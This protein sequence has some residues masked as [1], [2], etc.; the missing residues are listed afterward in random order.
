MVMIHVIFLVLFLV[1]PLIDDR[2]H[3][4]DALGC[5]WGRVSTHPLPADIVVRLLK[6]NGFEKVK[7]FEADP[8][9]LIALGKSGIQVMVGIPNDLLPSLASSVRVAEEWVV[10]NVSVYLSKYGVDIRYIAIGN[11]PFLESN[12]GVFNKV[13][14][15]ALQN[16]QAAIIKAGLSRQVK[17]TVP[18]N[19]NVYQTENGL[20][21]GGNFRSDVLTVVSSIV[22]FLHDNGGFLTINIYP[23]L[24]LHA[25]PNFP[26]TY[27]FF[28]GGTSAPV[29]DGSI[30]YTNVFE[31]NYDTF[32]FALEKNGFPT[33][34]VVVGEIGWPTDGDPNA[35]ANY[36]R[37]F[38]QGLLDRIIRKSGTPKRPNLPPD[39]YIFSLIDENAK[40]IEP[41]NFERHW[42]IFNYDGTIKY[43]L[44]FYN[45]RSLVAAK[46]VKYMEKQWC[47]LSP[48]A[49]I[50]DPN[51]PGSTQYACTYS[52]CTSLSYGSSCNGLDVRGNISYAFNQFYQTRNQQ[53]GACGFGNL[54][55]LTRT[56]PSQQTCRFEV[57]IDVGRR[58]KLKP[59]PFNPPSR[60]SGVGSSS[61]FSGTTAAVFFA[62][63]MVLFY[64]S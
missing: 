15:P 58:K 61:I 44:S 3:V 60:R 38:N 8:S 57:M 36:A 54:A 48:T 59:S 29:V 31:A 35:N 22:A 17:L 34:S 14:F 1:Q 28:D 19:A 23:F 33:M 13:I 64:C 41:G 9:A 4:V 30:T 27:A 56:D 62:T 43:P 37:H 21:S 46:G 32:I 47:V 50:A 55:K 45:G 18:F 63:M 16:V 24:S 20:P 6:D 25:D 49:S 40:S 53:N 12:R 7:L 26:L 39:I 11:E 51:V 10:Q 42:G 5:N 52:D 2:H